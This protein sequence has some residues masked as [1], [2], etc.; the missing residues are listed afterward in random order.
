MRSHNAMG[1]DKSKRAHSKK[2]QRQMQEE[3]DEEQHAEAVKE[4]TP[5]NRAVSQL[6]QWGP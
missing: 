6:C 2:C 3:E 5:K 4:K 1:H